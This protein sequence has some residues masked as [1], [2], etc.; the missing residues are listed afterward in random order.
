MR[1]ARTFA[2]SAV[3][4]SLLAAAF[5]VHGCAA[6]HAD[7][8]KPGETAAAVTRLPEANCRQIAGVNPL[9][10][11]M[12]Y[13]IMTPGG[14]MPMPPT[15]YARLTL[16]SFDG[17]TYADFADHNFMNGGVIVHQNLRT[18]GSSA[19]NTVDWGTGTIAAGFTTEGLVG[20]FDGDGWADV[21][22]HNLSTGAITVHRNL[23]NGTFGAA[24]PSMGVTATGTSY[25]TLI[26]DFTGDGYADFADHNLTSGGFYIH[27]NLR[28]GTFAGWG[29]NWGSGTSAVGPNLETLVG[30]FNGDH[31]ADYADHNTA[32]GQLWVH[33][34]I[35]ATHSF[36]TATA[37]S[38]TTGY[39]PAWEVMIGDFT[40]DGWA[41]Y[42][43]RWLSAY[44]NDPS[45]SA[46]YVHENLRNGSFAPSG[47][48]WGIGK[49]L[50]SGYTNAN[51]SV[52]YDVL[53]QDGPDRSVL[54]FQQALM[55]AGASGIYTV[56]NGGGSTAWYAMDV[57]RVG[58]ATVESIVNQYTFAP[59]SA[60]Y[61]SCTY[62][63]GDYQLPPSETGGA[64]H[65]YAPPLVVAYDPRG[66]NSCY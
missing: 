49:P 30:D 51:A 2:R 59:V 12:D 42:A 27:E 32:T 8:V 13:A 18:G 58:A 43:D 44:S 54:A 38:A 47:T 21:A 57:S 3:I 20:D 24:G 48:N 6:E 39:G 16:A 17:D 28:N 56:S 35:P 19:F 65:P 62:L 9:G 14:G 33:L 52:I 15:R 63:W 50:A 26:A 53:G 60:G 5:A 55:A 45:H 22:D 7:D 11:T 36:S 31:Y 10:F 66:C 25:E 34:A 29:V 46:F 40:G 61:F 4:A 1:I 23:H 64:T 37:Q 41:D